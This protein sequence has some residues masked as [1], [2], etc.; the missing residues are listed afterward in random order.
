MGKDDVFRRKQ[1]LKGPGEESEA[2]PSETRGTKEMRYARGKGPTEVRQSLTKDRKI[3]S[4]G[5]QDF[6]QDTE[7]ETEH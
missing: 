5:Y 6:P 7:T 1:Q 2:M 3:R 4:G